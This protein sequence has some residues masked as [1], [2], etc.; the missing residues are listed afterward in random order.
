MGQIRKQAI[1]SSI[2]IY[3]GFFIGFINTWF[4]IRKGSNSFTPEEYGLTRLFFDVGQL[5]YAVASLGVISVIYKFFPYYSDNLKKKENDLYTWS[6]IF[7][8]LGFLLT[9]AGGLIFEPLIVRKFSGRSPLFVDYY[10]WIFIFGFGILI[11]SILEGFSWTLKKTIYSN[12]L[13]ETGLRILSLILILLFSFGAINFDFFIKLFSFQ[14]LLIACL[15]ALAL[16]FAKDFVITFKASRV[17]QKFKKKMFSL[18]GYVYGGAII[19]ILSQVADSIIIASVSKGGLLDTGVYNLATYIATLIQVPQRSIVAVTIPILSIA[20]KNK[21][22][23]EIDR[24]YKRSSIN[25]LLLG[26]FI[27]IG[28]WLNIRDAFHLLN[29]Q[30]EY[31]AGIL[32]V[33]ILGITKII[34]A[35]TGINGQIIAT[36]TQW[37]FEFIT[38]VLLILLILPL[39]YFLVKKYGIIGS[40]FANLV[41]FSIYNFVRYIFL[42]KKYNLQPF[43]SKTI[44]SIVL[45]VVSYFISYLLFKE[46]TGWAGI[47]LRSTLFTIFFF[48]GIFAMKLTPDAMQL[49]EVAKKRFKPPTSKG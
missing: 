10:H 22:L 11:F 26:L 27:F 29:I 21:N 24:I 38:G 41:S 40:A 49:I 31:E 20:W 33:L 18:A 35:G 37:R 5:M 14:F 9:I 43:T 15:L 3:I 2:V 8:I 47:F 25:L 16:Y 19:I 36:S 48:T 45:A 12:F 7:P 17:T 32:V 23:A 30:T 44:L 6:F 13:R 1:I 42:W 46:M 39:N 34:D 4:F 28:V